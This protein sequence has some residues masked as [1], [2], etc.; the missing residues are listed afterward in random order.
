VKGLLVAVIFAGTAKYC[1]KPGTY[2]KLDKD[3]HPSYVHH[4]EL[5][6]AEDLNSDDSATADWA[7]GFINGFESGF[8]S[9]KPKSCEIR[10]LQKTKDSL[11]IKVIGGNWCP[12][13]RREVPRLCKVLYY[14]GLPVERFSY[15]RVD[16]D[17]KPL[18][19][20]FAKTHAFKY[21]PAIVVYW[22]G[23]E[24]G[25]IEES[26]EKSIEEDLLTILKKR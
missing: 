18:A 19:D 10:R 7:K 17:K 13:T 20:D 26:P 1:V 16:R 21:I 9:Y 6:L 11:E 3:P 22:G 24:L 2:A 15:F 23:K 12:D 5:I 8:R 25:Q 14:I 4:M